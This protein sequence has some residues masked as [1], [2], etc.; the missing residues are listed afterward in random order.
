MLPREQDGVVDSHLKV[1]GT[2]NLRVV[3]ASS[4]PIIPRGNTQATVFTVAE[5][6]A[7]IIKCDI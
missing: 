2:Q 4:V 6:A 3:D 5:K 1:Y 7:D